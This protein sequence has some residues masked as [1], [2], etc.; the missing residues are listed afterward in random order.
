MSVFLPDRLEL[1]KG[2]PSLRRA[3]L[4]QVV[5][6]LWP[7]RP[8]TRRAYSQA[9]A[10][11]N[12]LLARVR[13]GRLGRG[14][15]RVGRSSSRA[16]ASRCATTAPRPRTAAPRASPRL[17]AELGLAGEAELRYRPRS[18][19]ADAEELAAELAE[20][21][22]ADLERGFTGPRPA[23]RRPRAAARRPR[24]AR[25]RLPG[26]AAARACWRCCWPSAPCWPTSAARRRCCCSTTS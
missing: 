4:D 13:A 7:A 2:P 9:L 1:I 18:R 24:A 8:A 5:A 23:P 20:R 21:L 10:Q 12:A 3:H 25:L 11:R 14:A 17:A 16:T 19:A 15:A 26:R 22:D 6:A